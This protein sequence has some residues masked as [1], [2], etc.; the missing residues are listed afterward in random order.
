RTSPATTTQRR[1]RCTSAPRPT[2]WPRGDSGPAAPEPG[3]RLKAAPAPS[4]PAFFYREARLSPARSLPG[5]R[6]RR[7]RS[8]A[9][10]LVALAW[11]VATPGARAGEDIYFIDQHTTLVSEYG[12]TV[13]QQLLVAMDVQP[14]GRG[15]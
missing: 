1:P 5:K 4:G 14:E 15:A 8:I 10:L 2:A 3:P 11:L 7:M 9:G 12:G 6:G 13:E